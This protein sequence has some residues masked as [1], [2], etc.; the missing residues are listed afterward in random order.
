MENLHTSILTIKALKIVIP[1]AIVLAV[2]VIKLVLNRSQ[3]RIVYYDDESAYTA[4]EGE[5]EPQN[6]YDDDDEDD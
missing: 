5:N 1:I 4:A 6:Q 2:F 3:K